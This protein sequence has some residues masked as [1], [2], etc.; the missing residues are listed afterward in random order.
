MFCVLWW[1]NLYS[2]LVLRWYLCRLVC[3]VCMV[4]ICVFVEMWLV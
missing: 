2:S 3:E 4:C 1:W